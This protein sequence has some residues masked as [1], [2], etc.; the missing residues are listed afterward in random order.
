[1]SCDEP[2][3]ADEPL[4][5]PL[6]DDEL[7]FRWPGAYSRADGSA[8]PSSLLRCPGATSLARTSPVLWR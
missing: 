7:D 6:V 8:L 4:V 2:L 5:D 3:V 1:L